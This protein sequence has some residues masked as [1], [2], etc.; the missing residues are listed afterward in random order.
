MN[1]AN[2]RA[3]QCCKNCAY[4]T[5][6]VCMIR[7]IKVQEIVVC[8]RFQHAASFDYVKV[9][10]WKGAESVVIRPAIRTAAR[11]LVVASKAVMWLTQAMNR[12]T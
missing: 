4:L 5:G 7:R 12:V 9:A 8:D 11:A 10:M 2:L 1:Y 6:D 3:A